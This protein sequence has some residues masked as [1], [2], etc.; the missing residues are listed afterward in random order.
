MGPR[1]ILS[2]RP[3]VL[4]AACCAV[5]CTIGCGKDEPELTTTVPETVDET[6][7]DATD[8]QYV[9][10]SQSSANVDYDDLS[11]RLPQSPAHGDNGSASSGSSIN[12]SLTVVAKRDVTD[13]FSNG[14]TQRRYRMCL[15]TDKSVV[16]HGPYIEYYPNG[17]K[18][19]LGKYANRLQDGRWISW[20]SNGQ[21]AKLGE[22]KLG[23]QDGKWIYGNKDGRRRREETYADGKRNGIWLYYQKDAERLER[24]VE[25]KDDIR[26]GRSIEYYLNGKRKT[27]SEWKNNKLEG[28]LLKWYDNGKKFGYEEY[29]GG[30]RNGRAIMWSKSGTIQADL[31]YRDGRRVSGG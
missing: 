16:R 14:T 27:S 20:Y 21:I 7:V 12:T 25:W 26:E 24:Q 6:V 4:V 5:I 19:K 17:K 31:V 9:S 8:T 13:K 23:V 30:K 3:K 1:I 28:R 10:S 29:K 22:Y 11:G 15:M 2:H 18:F